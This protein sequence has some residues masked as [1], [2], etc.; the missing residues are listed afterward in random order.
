MNTSPAPPPTIVAPR[1]A[2]AP[3]PGVAAVAGSPPALGRPLHDPAPRG[4][5]VDRGCE[6]PERHAVAHREDELHDH[7]PRAAP[8]DR[9][10]E[11]RAVAARDHFAEARRRPIHD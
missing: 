8:H 4:I 1:N 10:A 6:P 3:T 11:N 9:G 2:P 7:F 5:G